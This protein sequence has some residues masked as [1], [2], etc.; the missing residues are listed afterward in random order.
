MVVLLPQSCTGAGGDLPASV[1]RV[2]LLPCFKVYTD[3]FFLT[4]LLSWLNE[5][6]RVLYTRVLYV[7]TVP[8]VLLNITPTL[9][10]LSNSSIF[11]RHI[12]LN[13]T[14]QSRLD[15]IIPNFY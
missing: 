3:W 8:L 9:V 1:G 15:L 4:K 7:R 14:E 5:R 10:F 6:A 11:E 12:R 2:R 13:R